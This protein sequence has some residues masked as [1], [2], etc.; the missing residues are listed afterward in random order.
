ML[1]QQRMRLPIDNEVIPTDEQK[2]DASTVHQKMEQFI[3]I[4]KKV[5]KAAELNI[6]SAQKSP[7]ETYNRKHQVQVL[8]GGTEVVL[9]NTCQKHWKG[10]KM[11]PLWL[12]PY[13]I[14]R[15]LGKN[16]YELRNMKGEIMKRKANINC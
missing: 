6:L 8:S 2:A 1:F 13:S 14:N 10:G 4:R 3:Y 12:G 5:F 7:K 15:C 11:E 16:L 9:E